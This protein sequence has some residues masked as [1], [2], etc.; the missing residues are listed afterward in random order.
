M[1]IFTGTAIT[2][3]R[4]AL[5]TFLESGT[6]PLTVEYIGGLGAGCGEFISDYSQTVTLY[7]FKNFIV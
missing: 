1:G 2:I 3:I 5:G 6:P 4:D 7:C